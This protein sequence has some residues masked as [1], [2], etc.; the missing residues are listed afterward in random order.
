M[1]QL[2]QEVGDG[3]T[4]RLASGPWVSAIGSPSYPCCAAHLQTLAAT[5]RVRPK[6]AERPRLTSGMELNFLG[7]YS[8]SGRDEDAA[9]DIAGVSGEATTGSISC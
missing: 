4:G 2:A 9:S 1:V 6:R 7:R 5:T 3:G 8:T